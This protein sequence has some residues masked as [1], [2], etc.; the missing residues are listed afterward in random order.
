MDFKK[1]RTY[2]LDKYEI[3]QAFLFIGYVSGNDRLYARLK[4]QGYKL[5]FKPTLYLPNGGVKGNVDAELVLHS[6]IEYKNYNKAL[7]VSNDG[8]FYCLVKYLKQN[9]KLV[10][11][12]IPDRHRYS[13]L[14]RKFDNYIVYMNYLEKKLVYKKRGIT[15]RTEP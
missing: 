7:I 6:M 10:K 1:F 8:D 14:L 5:I 3:V 13:S 11:L 4:N 2:L 12:M 9:N 15:L